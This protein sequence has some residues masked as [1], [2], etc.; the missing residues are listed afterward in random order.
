MG[1]TPRRSQTG[2]GS[3]DSCWSQGAFAEPRVVAVVVPARDTDAAPLDESNAA[4]APVA[5]D[6][7]CPHPLAVWKLGEQSHRYAEQY[8]ATRKA[9]RPLWSPRRRFVRVSPCHG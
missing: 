3:A 9:G 6:G 5:E 7:Q 1:R 8:D 4:S 2:A